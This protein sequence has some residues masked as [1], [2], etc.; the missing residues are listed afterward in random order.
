[1]PADSTP[2]APVTLIAQQAAA[3]CRWGSGLSSSRSSR[4]CYHRAAPTDARPRPAPARALKARRMT[5]AHPPRRTM[6]RQSPTQ[7]R[8][9]DRPRLP[10]CV[11]P[12]QTRLRRLQNYGS[13]LL[14]VRQ[15]SF[16]SGHATNAL[17]PHFRDECTQKRPH[18]ILSMADQQ[19]DQQV[20]RNIKFY[21]RKARL[22]VR[23]RS[24]MGQSMTPRLT[25]PPA[26]RRHIGSSHNN[27]GNEVSIIIFH[28]PSWTG[29]AAPWFSVPSNA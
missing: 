23:F 27:I 16:G 11:S 21:A 12:T 20:R 24:D 10:A 8:R 1:M 18:I 25:S 6:P 4:S 2:H 13:G 29:T 19:I 5:G 15:N 26:P 22:S 17:Q 28:S 7:H 9:S 14:E 3:A